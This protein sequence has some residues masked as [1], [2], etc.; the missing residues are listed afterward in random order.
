MR[1][2]SQLALP[3][4]A[5]A[6]LLLFAQDAS[7]FWWPVYKQRTVIRG[8]GHFHGGGSPFI[9]G[10]AGPL[11]SNS[12]EAFLF[13]GSPS[14]ETFFFPQSGFSS[15]SFALSSQE[16]AELSAHR[17]ESARAEASK[18]TPS[19]SGGGV[20]P[21]VATP[22]TGCAELVGRLD[23]IEAR[24]G[25]L[26]TKLGLVEGKIEKIVFAIDLE[27]E[28]QAKAMDQ[29]RQESF[30]VDLLE[31]VGTKVAQSLAKNSSTLVDLVEEMTKPDGQRDKGK[32]DR[33]KKELGK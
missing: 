9:V 2:R 1:I 27:R 14:T 7:A 22:G 31:A 6:G 20:M 17:A 18:K 30:K 23:K 4:L 19:S 26:E 5:V 3:A 15:E 25:V 24:M 11:V 10:G 13:S 8:G 12:R 28:R 16:R 32:I 29:Q 21:V 33:L